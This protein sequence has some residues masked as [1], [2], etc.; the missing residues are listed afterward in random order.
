MSLVS[1]RKKNLDLKNILNL[2]KLNNKYL[3]KL[4]INYIK[5]NNLYLIL[6]QIK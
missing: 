2:K 6:L 1:Q 3:I 4:N 5:L